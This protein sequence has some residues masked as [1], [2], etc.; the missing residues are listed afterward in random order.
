MWLSFQ[1]VEMELMCD[2]C[3]SVYRLFQLM[4]EIMAEKENKTIIFVETKK[5]CDDLTRRMRRD[6]WEMTQDDDSSSRMNYANI[7]I[8][9][10]E[11]SLILPLHCGFVFLG[12]QPC[13]SMETRAS[14]RETGYSPVRLIVIHCYHFLLFV[15]D[16]FLTWT[17]VCVIVISIL[18]FN[19]IFLV[20]LC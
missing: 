8:N 18:L 11:Y 16:Y 10:S 14:Q 5:R 9:C 19:F 20:S 2:N 6:G 15:V 13:V 17:G 4:E 1:T 7:Y 3:L 12:G